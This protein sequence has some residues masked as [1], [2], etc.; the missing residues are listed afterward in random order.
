MKVSSL[1]KNVTIKQ[2]NIF[3][4]LVIFFFTMIFVGLLVEEMYEDYERA[5]EKSYVTNGE[6]SSPDEI[7]EIK[8]KKLKSIMIKTVLVIVTLSFILFALFLG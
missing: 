8:H 6:V 4:I 1:F 2:A 3:T 5:L 7:L